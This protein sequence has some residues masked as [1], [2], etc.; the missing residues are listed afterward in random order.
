MKQLVSLVAA[1]AATAVLVP[2][3]VSAQ[4]PQGYYVAVP[5]SPDAVAKGRVITRS[6]AWR[7]QNGALVADQA[8]ERAQVLCEL[9]ARRTGELASFSAKG[10]AFD[11]DQLAK[12]N[13]KAPRPGGAVVAAAK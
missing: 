11:A 8:P 10:A 5:A 12:C 2:A 9:L 1:L 4:T 3:A 6:T 13:A 7:M